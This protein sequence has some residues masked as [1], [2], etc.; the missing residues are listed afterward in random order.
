MEVGEIRGRTI[1]SGGIPV[2]DLGEYQPETFEDDIYERWLEEDL[3]RADADSDR[4]PFSMV[5]PPPNVTGTL[6]MGHALNSTLQ[7]VLA[8]WKRMQGHEVLWVPGTDHAGIATQNVVEQKLEEEGTDRHELGR[9]AFLE[10]VW[11]WKQKYGDQIIRQLKGLGVSCDWSRERFTM[12]EGLSS[13]VEEVFVNLYE[14][15][16]IYQGDYIVN[17]CPRCQTALSDI[18]V[19]HREVDG[20]W[21]HMEYP[22]VGEN[23]ALHIATTRPET[24][25]GDTAVAYHPDDERYQELEG[26]TARLPLVERE[27]PVVADQRVD[28]EFGS[29]L[30][31]VTPAH[32]DLDFRIGQD[33]DLELINLLNPDGSFN[34]SAGEA[35]A[36]L[37]R[38]EV[39]RRVVRDLEQEGYLTEIEDYRHQ[40]GHCY[41]CDTVIEPYV[42]KQWFVSMEE[43]AEPAI[44]VVR[45]G[46]VEFHPR[47]WENTYFEW[48]ENIRD[49]CISRQIWWGHRIPVWY[50]PDDEAF[51]AKNAREAERKA[52][53]H[54][55]EEVKLERDSDV[56]DTWFSSA[57]WPFSTLGWPKQTPD[58]EKFYPTDVLSTAFDIIYFWVARM[59]MMGLYSMDEIPFSDVYIHALIRDED[60]RK[61]SKSIG[62]VIDPLEVTEEYGCDAL[63]FTLCAMAAQGRDIRLSKDRIKGFRNFANK[64]WN[65]AK[66]LQ[67]A[68]EDEEDLDR[69]T[70]PV[71]LDRCSDVDRWILSRFHG[72]MRK[73]SGGLEG[74]DFDV[75]ANTLYQFT[76]HE[77]C[78]WYI[79]MSKLRLDGEGN[80]PGETRKV[81]YQ[82]LSGTLRALHP[83]MP[84][85]TDEIHRALGIETGEI[86]EAPW[87]EPPEEWVDEGLE[88]RVE[89][90]QDLI[91][92]GRHLKKEFNVQTSE[93]V[94]LKLNA[95]DGRALELQQY[96]PYVRSLAGVETLSVRREMPRPEMASTEVLEYGTVYLPLEGLIDVEQERERIESDLEDREQR[97]AELEGRLDNPQFRENAPDD[98]VEETR[99]ELEQVRDETDRLRET[100]AALKQDATV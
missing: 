21:Y 57:L 95:E 17:W 39:R 73:A 7:D 91:R 23:G 44:E 19:E 70:E 93:D 85:L 96:E 41:R 100:L 65:A 56:L 94:H 98:V 11:E 66:Y 47:R 14:D 22:V 63:R 32:D 62:N 53:E 97:I 71:D 37:D 31:K 33:H 92:S 84:F 64:V 16:L 58:L 76:W 78:D 82:V 55:G 42:S 27:I 24:M 12:D 61:M 46:E 6:H 59:I 87:P 2:R 48:M 50:G 30:V 3:F 52:R 86:T 75:Y 45:R 35:Y 36:G 88:E 29:G 60:G 28:P 54:Y 8:R 5:I 1:I 9:D 69:L 74:Y 20:H 38:D 40:V 72:A 68:L 49:W 13:A 90:L 15:G 80:H 43:L 77:Y 26:K 34:D 89:D 18:E 25:L 81:L 51:V 99:V 4:P 83:V 10:E 79:E 67:F